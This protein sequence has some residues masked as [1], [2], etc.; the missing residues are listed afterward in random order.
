[1]RARDRGLMPPEAATQ[2]FAV[3]SHGTRRRVGVGRRRRRWVEALD[4]AVDGRLERHGIEPS[5]DGLDGPRT[6]RG[7][8]EAQSV[9]QVDVLIASPLGDGGIAT[10]PAEDR[11]A[12]QGQDGGERMASSLGTS[13]VG[14]RGQIREQRGREARVQ[15]F[16]CRHR[17]R[18]I[19]RHQCH[20]LVAVG[21]LH[22][23][24]LLG[25]PSVLKRI[26]IV[27]YGCG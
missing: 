13:G 6:G 10:G 19:R 4:P 2:G 25:L 14:D 7:A 8:P 24:T 11:T 27:G 18:L 17:S 22:T 12:G 1:M 3:E 9:H 5:E 16:E 15:I 26:R 23:I 21:P 20:Q